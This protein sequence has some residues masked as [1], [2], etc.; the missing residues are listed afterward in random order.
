MIARKRAGQQRKKKPRPDWGDEEEDSALLGLAGKLELALT[1]TLLE[2]R[3]DRSGCIVAPLPRG[4]LDGSGAPLHGSGDALVVGGE[5]ERGRVAEVGKLR[6]G[7]V[8]V[9]LV[10]DVIM[11]VLDQ[12]A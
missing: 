1:R 5:A 10:V 8:H 11:M 4:T 12:R 2:S 7:A 6:R 9:P 3:V